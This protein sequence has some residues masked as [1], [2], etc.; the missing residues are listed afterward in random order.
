MPSRGGGHS[1][2]LAEIVARVVEPFDSLEA[3]ALKIDYAVVAMTISRLRKGKVGLEQTVRRFAEAFCE[4][5][6]EL[7]GEEIETQ[8]G[9]CDRHAVADWLAGIAGFTV[10]RPTP[11]ITYEGEFSEDLA[12]AY[13]ALGQ[14]SP[15][16]LKTAREVLESLRESERGIA[17]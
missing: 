7:Y 8:F 9:S 14:L 11:P 5:L 1:P 4:R 16:K 13:S 6:C 2:R 10:T 17:Q 12:A 3:A 15:N